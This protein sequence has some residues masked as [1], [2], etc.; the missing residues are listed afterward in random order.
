MGLRRA[1]RESSHGERAFDRGDFAVAETLFTKALDRVVGKLTKDTDAVGIAATANLGLGRIC[2]ARNDLPTADMRFAQVRQL[3]PD[4]WQGFYWAGCV[5]CHAGDLPRAEWFFN[6]VIAQDPSLGKAYVQRAQLRLCQGRD[7]LALRD[8]SIAGRLRALDERGRLLTAVV[9]SRHGHWQDAESYLVGLDSPDAMA[10]KGTAAWRRGDATAAFAAF[11]QALAGGNRDDSVLF[12]HGIAGYR[13]GRF[14]ASIESWTELLE[15]HPHHRPCAELVT[16][17]YRARAAQRLTGDDIGGA[18]ADLDTVG[19]RQP[20]EAL[21]ETISLLH[22]HA[23]VKAIAEDDDA[24]ARTHLRATR[25]PKAEHLIAH[26]S[27]VG[28]DLAAARQAWRR[29]LDT[30]P[31][32]PLAR[33]GLAICAARDN[34]LA[35]DDLRDLT[36]SGPHP[37]RRAAGHAI[38]TARIRRGEWAAA[39]DVLEPLTEDPW[40]TSVFAECLYR[41]GRHAELLAMPDNPWQQ[42]VRAAAGEADGSMLRGRPEQELALVRRAA[43]LT[44]ASDGDWTRAADLFETCAAERDSGL[45]EAVAYGL[46]GRHHRG[47]TLLRLACERDPADSR[48]GH[49]LA[50]MLLHLLSAEPEQGPASWQSCIGVWMSVVHDQEFWSAWRV[51]AERRYGCP[52]LPG[53]IDSLRTRVRELVERRVAEHGADGEPLLLRRE[54]EAARVLA[55]LGG[56]P[57]PSLGAERLVCGPLRIAELGLHHELGEFAVDLASDDAEVLFRTFSQ[58]GLAEAHLSAGRAAE[59]A[60]LALDLRCPT[61]RRADWQDEDEPRLCA[62][63][64]PDFD[65]YNPAFAALDHKYDELFECGAALATEALL[66]SA[67]AEIAKAEPDVSST[68]RWWT[69]AVS[70]AS[71]FSEEDVVLREIVDTALGRSEGLARKENWTEAITVLDAASTV[72]GT[73]SEKERERLCVSLAKQLTTR[74]ILTFNEDRDDAELARQDL[75]RAVAL[76]PHSKRASLNHGLVLRDMAYVQARTDVVEALR[77]LSEALREFERGLTHKPGDPDL[78]KFRDGIRHDFNRVTADL[79]GRGW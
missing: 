70:Q 4:N 48:L 16:A 55:E 65:R 69:K 79:L 2:L 30:R 9:L 39:C 47:V 78:V 41:V 17:A 75:S 52:V 51:D 49:A 76:A 59:A 36:T 66:E 43:A 28:A 10:V 72:V 40:R 22:A 64:C 61:C 56:L 38:A 53:T 58:L 33:L 12:H 29:I 63:A 15:R 25:H 77:L 42:V 13:L 20:S 50:V 8:L 24:R 62:P 31:S 7:G 54:H 21:D 6:A 45:I 73:R 14:S 1:R 44:A 74:G 26:L 3:R 71:R 68:T 37:I 19:R 18:I 11:D 57:L 46:S 34:E 67:R 32:D 27:Y 35:E 60:E 5:A 23:A